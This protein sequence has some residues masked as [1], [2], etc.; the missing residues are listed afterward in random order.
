MGFPGGSVGK[1][2][3]CNAGD[4]GLIPGLGGSPGEAKG[5]LLQYSGLELVCIHLDFPQY[6]LTVLMWQ[7][8]YD[9]NSSNLATFKVI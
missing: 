6:F 7:N 3:T 1:E 2:S 5:Y 9:L 8:T 4:L